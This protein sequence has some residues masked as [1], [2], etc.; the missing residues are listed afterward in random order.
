MAKCT[1]EDRIVLLVFTICLCFALTILSGCKRK[2]QSEEAR[3]DIP[4]EDTKDANT[5]E[6]VVQDESPEKINLRILYVGA[7]LQIGDSNRRDD[8]KEFLSKNFKE[9][10]AIDKKVFNEDK[11]AE[12]DVI[13]LDQ[14]IRIKREYLRPTVTIGV[15]GTKIGDYLDLKTGYL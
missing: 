12:F 15:A 1:K 3:Q 11:T 5:S 2:A 8:F 4:T 9:V 14:I 6:Q 13:L 7:P 10:V